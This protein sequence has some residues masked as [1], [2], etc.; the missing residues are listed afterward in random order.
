MKWECITIFETI[1]FIPKLAIKILK[2]DISRYFMN[3]LEQIIVWL[4]F[5]L[6]RTAQRWLI[7]WHVFD[8]LYFVFL[9]HANSKFIY[10]FSPEISQ[11]L[12]D[13]GFLVANNVLDPIFRITQIMEETNIQPRDGT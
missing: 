12:L 13:H 8:I 4:I 10:I 9:N 7:Y 3:T 2:L 1:V 11:Y 6:D 5:A